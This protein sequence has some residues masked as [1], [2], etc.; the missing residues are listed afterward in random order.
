LLLKSYSFQITFLDDYSWLDFLSIYVSG[1]ENRAFCNQHE[2]DNCF[3][4]GTSARIIGLQGVF[5][6]LWLKFFFPLS[7]LSMIYRVEPEKLA[8][9]VHNFYGELEQKLWPK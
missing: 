8:E 3:C 7:Q 4:P 1:V 6:L 2:C 9:A 5:N